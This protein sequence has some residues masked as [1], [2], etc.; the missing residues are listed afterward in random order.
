MTAEEALA[1]TESKEERTAKD[2]AVDFLKDLLSDGPMKE[3]EVHKEAQQ[4]GISRKT[5]RMALLELGIK[6]KKIGFNPSYWIWGFSYEDAL[7]SEDSSS[8]IEG[9]F[10]KFGNL[11]DSNKDGNKNVL[12][13]FVKELNEIDGEKTEEVKTELKNETEKLPIQNEI[14]FS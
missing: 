7:K 11:R 10:N 9:I 6:P 1:P 4:V 14:S 13:N 12:D 8:N 3:R 2:D 5:L